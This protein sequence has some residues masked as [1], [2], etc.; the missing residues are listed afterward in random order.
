[1]S[2]VGIPE[3]SVTAEDGVV[4]TAS[5]DGKGNISYRGV[6]KDGN[7]VSG[8]APSEVVKAAKDYGAGLVH[9]EEKGSENDN[10][11]KDGA[12]AQKEQKREEDGKVNRMKNIRERYGADI[13]SYDSKTGEVK[14][15]KNNEARGFL[16]LGRKRT[17]IPLSKEDKVLLKENFDNWIK[18]KNNSSLKSL[19]KGEARSLGEEF[20][21]AWQ[22]MKK[23]GYLAFVRPMKDLYKAGKLIVKGRF[24]ELRDRAAL[25]VHD[26]LLELG[27]FNERTEERVR[28]ANK[29]IE[30]R[31]GIEDRQESAGIVARTYGKPIKDI[32]RMFNRLRGRNNNQAV[33]VT[34]RTNGGRTGGNSR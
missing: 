32:R 25:R 21:E 5:W 20:G 11:P 23:D 18:K 6:D 2:D 29:K 4:W 14:A 24:R 3:F 8:G 17:E 34:V 22:R 15:F 7:K 12:I 30:E 13:F 19:T 33:P 28:S 9:S 10:K 31:L 1:M 16:G 27:V 26:N